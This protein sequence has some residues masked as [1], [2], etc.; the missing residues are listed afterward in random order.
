MNICIIVYDFSIRNGAQRVGCNVANELCK[1][2]YQ[3]VFVSLFYKRGSDS[4]KLDEDIKKYII[5][6][7]DSRFIKNFWNII[8]SLN[9]IIRHNYCNYIIGNGFSVALAT[10]I[11]SCLLNKP[12]IYWEQG[13]L[14]NEYYNSNLK[15]RIYRWISIKFSRMNITLT[16]ETRISLIKKFNVSS[17]K[18]RTIPNWVEKSAFKSNGYN[19]ESKIILTIG[20]ADPIKGFDRLIMIAKKVEPY[21]KGWEWHIW[22]SFDN[23]YGNYIVESIN[24]N[25]LSHFIIL[26]GETKDIYSVYSKASFFVMTS[27]YEGLPMVLL[28]AKANMLPLVS[29]DIKTGPNEIIE[30]EVNG[31]LIKDDDINGMAEKIKE[32][33]NK[34]ELRRKFSEYSY[35]KM[36]KYSK[37]TISENWSEMLLSLNNR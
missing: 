6:D 1:R 24:K 32:L 16:E 4:Y 29:F 8:F 23:T 7:H 34:P 10:F 33:I 36:D 11:S 2:G 37:S 20:N 21:A 5:I 19:K 28:E 30:N 27:R 26:M 31:F 35:I 9:E 14:E 15:S 12:F 13:C 17:S 22:G 18:T 3:V 25:N